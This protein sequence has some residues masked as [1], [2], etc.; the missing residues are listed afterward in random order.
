[1]EPLRRPAAFLEQKAKIG[2]ARQA[3]THVPEEPPRD[4]LQFLIELAPLENWERDILG[5][6]RAEAYYFAPRG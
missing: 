3:Q 4:V 6:V 5:I 2:R 1:M